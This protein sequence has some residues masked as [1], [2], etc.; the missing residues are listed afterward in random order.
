MARSKVA[1][2]GPEGGVKQIGAGLTIHK[3]QQ[4]WSL[5]IV[6]GYSGTLGYNKTQVGTPR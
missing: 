3:V 5:L 4:G 2:Y 6:L 1:N